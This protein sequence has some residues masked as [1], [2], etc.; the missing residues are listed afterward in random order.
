MITNYRDSLIVRQILHISTLVN[1]QRTVWRIEI[2]ML[3][4]IRP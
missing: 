2:L 4:C 1:V 3:V